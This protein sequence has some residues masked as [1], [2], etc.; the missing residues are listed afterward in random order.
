[1]SVLLESK[2]KQI[3]EDGTVIGGE[4]CYKPLEKQIE[5]KKSAKA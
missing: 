3:L 1:M 5:K 4:D 2:P